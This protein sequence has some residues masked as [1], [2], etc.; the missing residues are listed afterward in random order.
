MKKTAL[1]FLLLLFPIIVNAAWWNPLSWNWIERILDRSSNINSE[2]TVGEDTTTSEDEDKFEELRKKIEILEERLSEKEKSQE[3]KPSTPTAKTVQPQPNTVSSQTRPT[4]S[5]LTN[6]EI[7]D[8]VK[9]A[10]VYISTEKGSGSGFIFDPAGYILTNAHVVEGSSSV[11]VTL[12]NKRKFNAIVVGVNNLTN[13]VAILKLDSSGIYSSAKLGDSDTLVQGDEV[14]L[15]GFPLGVEGDV[16]FK[17]GT[18]SRKFTDTDIPYLEMSAEAHPGNSGGP[19][20]DRYGKVVGM[21][22]FSYGT[23]SEKIKFSIAINHIKSELFDLKA[24]KQLLRSKSHNEAE[25]A[26]RSQLAG[27]RTQISENVEISKAISKSYNPASFDYNEKQVLSGVDSINSSQENYRKDYL[28]TIVQGYKTIIEGLKV[29]VNITGSFNN[30]YSN[31]Q[32]G[33][34]SVGNNY[35]RKKL[36]DFSIHT[37]LKFTEYNKKMEEI[38]GKINAIEDTLEKGN[39][40]NTPTQYF[41]Q[42]RDLFKSSINYISTEQKTWLDMLWIRLLF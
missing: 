20:I 7:I 12:N 8:L 18:I 4:L 22:T 27:M 23:V 2:Q 34:D 38:Y 3:T 21:H 17:E 26:F 19:L 31:N 24:G 33:A 9:P 30:F 29:F 41:I 16:S 39:L 42:Q 32:S 25:S 13:D 10:V 11:E 6:K 15:L 28:Q 35:A 37:S 40:K 36:T 1:N 14:F 5:K